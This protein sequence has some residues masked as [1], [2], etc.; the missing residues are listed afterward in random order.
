MEHDSKGLKLRNLVGLTG[1]LQIDFGSTKDELLARIL[2]T[3]HLVDAP[4]QST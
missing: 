3:K 4:E 2:A 1:S